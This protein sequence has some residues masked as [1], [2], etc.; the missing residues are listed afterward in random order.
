MKILLINHYAG[1]PA[2]GMEFRPY[3]M[4]KEWVKAGHQVLII[5]GSHSHL[6]KQQP[7]PGAETIDGIQYYWIKLNSYKGNGVGR[8]LSI[9]AFVS[10]LW[11]NYRKYIG[12]FK[13]VIV[14]AS[15]TYPI[16]IYPAR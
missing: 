4:A 7:T 5:G 6:R 9:G 12:E 3:H 2:Y 10:K 13:P 16:D 1:C 15:S 11:C 14:I 8:I